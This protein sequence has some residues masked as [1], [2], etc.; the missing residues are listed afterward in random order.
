MTRRTH[1]QKAL[2]L[3]NNNVSLVAQLLKVQYIIIISWWGNHLKLQKQSGRSRVYFFCFFF[4]CF[5][6]TLAS[7]LQGKFHWIDEWRSWRL[8]HFLFCSLDEVV[9]QSSKRAR[10]CGVLRLV[11][12]RS[13]RIQ[14]RKRQL[15]ERVFF[16]GLNQTNR[17]RFSSSYSCCGVS[18]KVRKS[19]VD[20]F[21]RSCVK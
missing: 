11:V 20:R 18:L 10:E 21:V 13:L 19:V 9:V 1:H 5:Q 14:E 6:V 2:H 7:A 17:G 8:R 3:L 15:E 12:S 4:H 16:L